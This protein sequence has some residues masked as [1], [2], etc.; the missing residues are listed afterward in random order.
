MLEEQP[1]M[2]IVGEAENGRSAVAM[3]DELRPDVVI[4]D[5]TMPDLNGI[6][7]TLQI[8]AANPRIKVIAVSMHVERQF[9]T[10]MLAAKASA[11][12]PKD[13]GVEELL[14]AIQT[15][16]NDEVY[17]SPKIAGSLIVESLS[18]AE[19]RS[20]PALVALSPREREVLQL[21]A[22]G[23]NAKEIGLLLEL[24]T[25]TVEAHRRQ[26][27][28][29]LNLDSVAELTRYAIREGISVL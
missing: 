18:G 20:T 19:K 28:E 26:I 21:V 15:A 27:M 10:K 24:S 14:A 4:M 23:K 25:K 7:A 17:V 3:A 13:S 6:D 22:E 8:H 9:I 5:V 16:L 1:N 2:Q 12:L 11:Y 29:K